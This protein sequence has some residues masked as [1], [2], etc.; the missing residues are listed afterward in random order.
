MSR[1]AKA[2]WLAVVLAGL[3]L[4]AY[5]LSGWR[6]TNQELPKLGLYMLA[7]VATSLKRLDVNVLL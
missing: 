2:Y 7:A 6:P 4:S 1:Q 3:C 5:V